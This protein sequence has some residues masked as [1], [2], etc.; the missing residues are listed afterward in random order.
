LLDHGQDDQADDEPD[1]DVLQQIVQTMLLAAGA[2]GR[3]R[4]AL[5]SPLITS[6]DI[7][8]ILPLAFIASQRSDA[9]SVPFAHAAATR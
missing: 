4:P 9:G 7:E 6:A 3:P 2:P 8:W 5:P 1:A